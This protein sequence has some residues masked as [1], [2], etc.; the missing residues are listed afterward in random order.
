MEA[1]SGDG[2]SGTGKETSELASSATG[3]ETDWSSFGALFVSVRPSYFDAG[4]NGR[5]TGVSG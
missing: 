1:G 2:S 3:A 5:V 4:D